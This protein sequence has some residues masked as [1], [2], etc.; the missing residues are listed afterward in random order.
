VKQRFG[1]SQ[2][3]VVGYTAAYALR[4]HED[5]KARHR[6]GRA[7]YLLDVLHENVATYADIV[8]RILMS[9][10]TMGQACYYAGLQLQRDSMQNCPVD[11]GHCRSTAFTELR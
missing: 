4:L 11:T 1:A 7:G 3:A 10:G 8:K 5:R 2:A 9:G 6:V